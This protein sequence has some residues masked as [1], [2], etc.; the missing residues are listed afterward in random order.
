MEDFFMKKIVSAVTLA[1]L[2]AGAAFAD[3][4]FSY[5]G[6]NYFDSGANS[7]AGLGYDGDS[8][9]DCIALSI[10]QDNYGATLDV[11]VGNHLFGKTDEDA[12]NNEKGG[13]KIDEYYG[14][15]TFKA[16]STT[17]TAGVW[18]SRYVDRVT[19]D[20]RGV[21]FDDQDF[22]LFK[23]GVI[24]VKSY[25]T[26]NTNGAG[27]YNVAFDSDNL[28]M[29]ALAMVA[30]YTNTALPGT[31]MV[32]LGLV[33]VTG[34]ASDN[35]NG[36]LSAAKLSP[37][38]A[39]Q[40]N[41]NVL[42]PASKVLAGF[43]G[44][45]AYR[46]ENLFAVN[47]AVRSY[48]VHTAS[49]GLFFSPLMVDKLE[50]TA[51]VTLGFNGAGYTA[52]SWNAD[53]TRQTK[54]RQ[55]IYQEQGT[56]GFEWAVDLRARYAFSDRL[57]VTT[58]HNFSSY[59][60]DLATDASWA[61]NNTDL[62]K[63]E[64]NDFAMWNQFNITYDFAENLTAGFTVQHLAT[65]LDQAY[66][67]HNHL[68]IAPNLQIKCNDNAKFTIVTRAHFQNMGE[69]DDDGKNLVP[70]CDQGYNHSDSHSHYRFAF[71]VPVI[72]SFNY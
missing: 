36:V 8:R 54:G 40:D 47:L 41:T 65:D 43:V 42:D 7:G 10:N 24:N 30:A 68:W 45:V 4:S 1:S 70:P 2:L 13:M 66:T 39:W 20:K 64:G 53:G 46:Q 14:W 63:W 69:A 37:E 5:T 17:F 38:G 33:D 32:K 6:K 27:K 23:P 11:D 61:N 48:E 22:E 26:D 29:G 34:K 50:A 49:V 57:S 18:N 31:L 51:G 35:T 67:Q 16:I 59:I 55:Q 12:N 25:R 19:T 9:K 3:I 72:F 58:M 60:T 28:T 52:S 56:L 15:M 62:T 21:N 71:T 44:E